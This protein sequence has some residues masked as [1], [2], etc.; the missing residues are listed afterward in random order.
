QQPEAKGQ[1]KWEP[2]SVASGAS[3]ITSKALT[4]KKPKAEKSS[5]RSKKNDLDAE[6]LPVPSPRFSLKGRRD[7]PSDPRTVAH[8]DLVNRLNSMSNLIDDDVDYDQL[9]PLLDRINAE[10][11]SHELIGELEINDDEYRILK[12]YFRTVCKNGYESA[13][14]SEDFVLDKPCLTAMIEVGKRAERLDYWDTIAQVLY[15][16]DSDK[17]DEAW[18]DGAFCRG[19]LRAGKALESTNRQRALATVMRHAGKATA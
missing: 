12:H 19:M 14:D 18:L 11:G 7:A 10:F 6:P 15:G 16:V 9:A 1:K 3:K 8:G 5:R 2:S 4:E 13:S 17:F